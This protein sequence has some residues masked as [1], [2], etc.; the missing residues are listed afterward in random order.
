MKREEKRLRG[1]CMCVCV[2]KYFLTLLYLH[3]GNSSYV[4]NPFLTKLDML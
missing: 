2:F 4:V 1:M 3:I